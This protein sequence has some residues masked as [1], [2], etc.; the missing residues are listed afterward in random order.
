MH[1][2]IIFRIDYTGVLVERG[3]YRKVRKNLLI[4]LGIA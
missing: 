4:F 2:R 3:T 1:F